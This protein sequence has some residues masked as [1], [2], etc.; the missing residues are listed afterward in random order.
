M[1]ETGIPRENGSSFFRNTDCTFFPCHEDVDPNQFNCLFCYCPL[2]ALGPRCGGDF[3]YTRS[4]V[5]DCS[6]CTRLHRGDAGAEIVKQLF[7]LLAELAN[8]STA[9]GELSS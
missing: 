9:E 5:K 3:R 8:A 1:E 6:S 4:G 7:P 2:Y